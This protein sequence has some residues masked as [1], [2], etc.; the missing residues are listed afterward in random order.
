MRALE[1]VAAD[2]V[3]ARMAAIELRNELF[4]HLDESITGAVSDCGIDDDGDLAQEIRVKM[5][6]KIWRR[7]LAGVTEWKDWAFNCAKGIIYS[8]RFESVGNNH[9]AAIA[10]A[11]TE[12]RSDGD[13][14]YTP[15]TG[16]RQALRVAV[17]ELSPQRR[18]V[19]GLHLDGKSNTEIGTAL[20]MSNSAVR[21]SLAT[22]RKQLREKLRPAS[23]A[24]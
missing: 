21:E 18:R 16:Q 14:T 13:E 8:T 9:E 12:S 5:L 19:M 4:A 17:S 7:D 22:A 10:A 15:T 24:A 20:N 23:D 1:T 2:Y 11:V 6:W 3:A